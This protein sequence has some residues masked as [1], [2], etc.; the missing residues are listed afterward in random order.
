MIARQQTEFSTPW[1][2][3]VSKFVAGES[4]P[5]YALRMSD[6]VAVVA[7]T[8]ACELV[9]VRQYRPAVERLTLELPSG[10]IERNETPEHAA[11]RELAEE[12]GLDA[13]DIQLLGTLLSDTGRN[14]NRVWCYF[15]GALKPCASFVP[16]PGVERVLVPAIK[17]SDLIAKGEFDFSL[18]VAALML[19]VLRHGTGV[20]GLSG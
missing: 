4:K 12:C 7:I 17:M 9:L 8:E 19:A 11:R 18:H 6:Y 15:A 13:Q 20:V 1:F 10:H 16:E 2:E 3:L 5:Y 14:E